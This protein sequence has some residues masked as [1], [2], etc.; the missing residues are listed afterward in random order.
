[1]TATMI[2]PTQILEPDADTLGR[3]V[4]AVLQ[5]RGTTLPD[6]YEARTR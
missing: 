6:L 3:Y 4:G 5:Y 1:M 2:R